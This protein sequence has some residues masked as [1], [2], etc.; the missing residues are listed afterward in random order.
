MHLGRP[1]GMSFDAVN[2]ANPDWLNRVL[3]RKKE[4]D[5]GV[6]LYDGD[7]HH[8]G[9]AQAAWDSRPPGSG[10]RST[11]L[12][13]WRLDQTAL[14]VFLD[15]LRAGDVALAPLPFLGAT[16]IRVILGDFLGEGGV[17]RKEGSSVQHGIGLEM[18]A[19]GFVPPTFTSLTSTSGWDVP[20]GAT[21]PACV[22]YQ[23]EWAKTPT[24]AERQRLEGIGV[25]PD[26]VPWWPV[27][28]QG[29]FL[30]TTLSADARLDLEG[31]AFHFRPLDF[32][33]WINGV[34]W[35]SEWPKYEM[36]AD[37][38]QPQRPRSRRV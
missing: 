2:D 30:D 34:T 31:W 10:V 38:A 14:Q 32:M 7:A 22:F 24:A 25:D 8:G 21:E 1:E 16:P 5:V 13:A 33:R 20:A 26:L 6:T 19:S 12:E 15:G 23:S 17:I 11:L 4:C 3:A 27:G 37:V 28:V 9:V 36:G 18:F 29:T 35:A